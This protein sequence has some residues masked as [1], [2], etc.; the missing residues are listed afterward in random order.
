MRLHERSLNSL[1][2]QITQALSISAFL[3]RKIP[4][5]PDQYMTFSRRD[6]RQPPA[7]IWPLVRRKT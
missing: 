6:V 7:H 4:A 2:L 1:C 5:C 3:I